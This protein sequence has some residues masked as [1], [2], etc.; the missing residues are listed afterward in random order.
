MQHVDRIMMQSVAQSVAPDLS[1]S[2][3]KL[4][5]HF[6]IAI[7]NLSNNIYYMHSEIYDLHYNI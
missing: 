6:S 2:M 5:V 1:S 7:C 4:I 3:N